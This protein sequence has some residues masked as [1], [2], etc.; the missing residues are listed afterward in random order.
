ML[1]I[2]S[3]STLRAPVKRKILEEHLANGN[4]TIEIKRE[5]GGVI[6]LKKS[7]IDGEVLDLTSDNE[8]D[9]DAEPDEVSD[10]AEMEN[11]EDETSNEQTE[12]SKTAAGG[13]T[14]EK[15]VNKSDKGKSGKKVINDSDNDIHDEPDRCAIG[16]QLTNLINQELNGEGSIETDDNDE[17]EVDDGE[18]DSTMGAKGDSGKKEEIKVDN[19]KDN[20]IVAKAK[21]E[22]ETKA[23]DEK[24]VKK[25]MVDRL[26]QTVP[27]VVKYASPEEVELFNLSSIEQRNVLL[28]KSRDLDDVKKNMLSLQK[29]ICQLLKIIVPDFDYGEP[30]DIEQVILDFIKVNDSEE[31]PTSSS[32]PS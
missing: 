29:N 26:A 25:E 8:E 23:K 30:E 22:D 10:T 12:G 5:G 31:E 14:T 1:C 27:V 2:F 24:T 13:K 16:D 32:T 4:K 7:K 3:F 6:K 19:S 11:G 9:E 21:A 28:E 17:M 20:T 15:R 18:S